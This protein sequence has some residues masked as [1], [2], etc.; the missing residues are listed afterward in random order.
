MDRQEVYKLIDGER[1]Y[2]DSMF[3]DLDAGW[4]PSE[5][6]TFIRKIVRLSDDSFYGCDTI[7]EGRLMMM[8]DIRKI[9]AVAVSAMEHNPTNPRGK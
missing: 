5:W 9:A 1:D 8:D 2:Q 6:M 4:T 7:E 3:D